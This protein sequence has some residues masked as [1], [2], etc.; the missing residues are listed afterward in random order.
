MTIMQLIIDFLLGIRSAFASVRSFAEI[1][2]ERGAAH[3]D[4]ASL[5]QVVI[6]VSF[7]M[8]VLPRVVPVAAWTVRMVLR[9][10]HKIRGGKQQPKRGPDPLAADAARVLP[11]AKRRGQILAALQAAMTR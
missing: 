2:H 6:L 4:L 5:L 11:R 1:A 8:E 7:A 10:L 9:V 3:M